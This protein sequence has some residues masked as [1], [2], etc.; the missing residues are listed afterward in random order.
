MFKCD[1]SYICKTLKNQLH[2]KLRKKSNIPQRTP[3]QQA[4]A[5]KK[6]STFYRK[7]RNYEW[8]LDDES[9][10]TLSH[11]TINNNN[12]YYT[13]DINL[14]PASVKYRPRRKFEPKCLVWIAMSAKGV[15][16]P[17]ICP[18]GMA[19]NQHV[20]LEE[21]IESKLVLFINMHHSK[22]NY[23]FWPDLASSHYADKVLDF[24][25][26]NRIN[27]VDK[28]DNPANLPECRPIEDFWSILKGKVYAHN[29]Q[30]KDIPTLKKRI[31][32]C[33]KEIEPSTIQSLMEGVVKRIDEVR[34]R[35]V[36]EKRY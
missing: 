6:C 11:A 16:E 21:C 4:E 24:L 28:V 36:I 17:F 19:I 30:A 15:S 2:I 29:W 20:Y 10:F 3:Q 26:E 23:V 25:I 13:S 22:S 9:Y 8:I 31:K 32:K 35:G 18:S 5:R 34:R 33:L 12:T 7:Y 14:T 1:Q 27:H